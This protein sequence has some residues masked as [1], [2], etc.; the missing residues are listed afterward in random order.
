MM[1]LIG[2]LSRVLGGKKEPP[3]AQALEIAIAHHQ[4]GHLAEAEVLYRQILAAAPKDSNALHLLGVI[5][6]QHGDSKKAVELISKALAID[7]SQPLAYSNLGAAYLALNHLDE[8]EHCIRKA[9]TLKPDY[10]AAHNN[11][12]SVFQKRGW[13]DQAEECFR[14]AIFFDPHYAEALTN[15][16]NLLLERGNAMEAEEYSRKAVAQDHTNALY[17]WNLALAL[18]LRGNYEEGLPLYE[19]RLESTQYGMTG[20][21]SLCAQLQHCPAWHREPLSGKRIL[22][23]T[24]QGLG[25]S[26]MVM[27]YLSLLKS[28]GAEKVIIYC[29]PSLERLMRQLPGVDEVVPQTD[30]LPLGEFDLHCPAMSLP[31]LFGTRLDSIPGKMPY[32]AVPNELITHWAERLTGQ[33]DTTAFVGAALA[34]NEQTVIKV[35]LTW[36]GSRIL[37]DDARRSIPLYQFAPLLKISNVQI[38]NLQK[39]DKSKQLA[40]LGWN[41]PDWMNECQDFMD[42]AALLANLDLVI[43]VDTAVAHLAGAMGKQ[44]WL[45][46]RYESEWRWGL[47][48]ENSPWYPTM[49][50]FR[51]AEPLEWGAVICRVAEEL[52]RRVA[53]PCCS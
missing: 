15:L 47:E 3:P 43:S 13:N 37:R 4:A 28:R 51:Q 20:S 27:R 22:V 10:A 46:N 25:D 30:A 1:G 29:E 9:L 24:E 36:A 32:L 42:T 50:I 44:V 53:Q 23:W 6:Q 40:Q 26:I 11:L 18:L 7:P 49:R 41:I 52:G 34:A 45:L 39:G 12:G 31:Y 48:G 17:K 35:G 38:I 14:K 8:A 2:K 19:K 33:K 16:G 5:A 21:T